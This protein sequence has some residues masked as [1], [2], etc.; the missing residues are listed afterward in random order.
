MP[1]GCRYSRHYRLPKSA[2][3][4]TRF[5]FEA[6]G[7]FMPA[8]RSVRRALFATVLDFQLWIAFAAR[9]PKSCCHAVE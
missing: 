2:T 5:C 3:V 4:C 1:C 7:G 9:S 6:S 8:V